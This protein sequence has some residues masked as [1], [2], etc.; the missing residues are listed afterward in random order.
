MIFVDRFLIQDR[1]QV[2]VLDNGKPCRHCRDKKALLVEQHLVTWTVPNAIVFYSG[3]CVGVICL[4]C[5][6]EKQSGN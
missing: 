5:L 1:Q 4:D 6:K 2:V 3:E